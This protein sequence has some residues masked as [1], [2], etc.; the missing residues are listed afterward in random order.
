ML[1]KK[2]DI[3]TKSKLDCRYFRGEKPC[4]FKRLCEDCKEYKP[5]GTKILIIK[6][7]AIGD[8][9]RTTPLLLGLKEKYPQS[10]IT[11]VMDRPSLPLLQNNSYIDRVCAL[12]ADTV[13]RLHVECF[14]LL[15]CL[16]KETVAVTLTS[17]VQAEEKKGIGFHSM[18]GNICPLNEEALYMF[19]L[20]LNDDLKFRLNQK[21]YQEIIFEAVGLPYRGYEYIMSL[22]E[23]ERL[24]ADNFFRGN[25]VE[26]GDIL[27]GL[28]TG[29]GTAFA[30]KQWTV[31]GYVEL[32]N[33]LVTDLNIKVVLF[34]GPDEVERN[35]EIVS[36]VSVPVIDSGCDNTLLRFSALLERCDAVVTGDTVGMHI[37]IGLRREV[38]ALFGPTAPQEIDLYGRGE[39]I[40]SRMDCAPCYRSMCDK[41]P[42]C[43]DDIS[44]E[45]VFQA[46]VKRL[47][48]AMR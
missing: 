16:D 33:K 20:G 25:G 19:E 39:K 12:D 17:V 10:F 36:K 13:A 35:K 28:N 37:A 26:R 34:G 18:T 30:N 42:M 7:N 11:W 44:V 27:V 31:G 40:V 14:D 6:L 43:M 21:T 47:P 22:P 9:L 15:I 29:A 2:S 41:N 4:Q 24:S 1:N 8:V 38:I 5:M 48:V 32:A 23:E 3:H 45:E 46:V